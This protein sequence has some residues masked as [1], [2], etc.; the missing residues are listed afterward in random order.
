MVVP[1]TLQN[2]TTSVKGVQLSPHDSGEVRRQKFA[3][4]I[5]DAMYQFLGLLDVDGTVL[6]I[7]RAALEGA[8][9]VLDDVVGKPFWEARWWAVS[10]EARSQVRSMVEHAARGHFIRR[11]M[12]VFGD[13]HGEKSIFVDFS[14]TPIRDDQGR[15][16][17]LLPEGRNISEKVAIQA[18]LTRKNGELQQALERLREI[19]GF[20]TKF[21]ANVSHELRTPLTLILGPV[22]QLL[23][24]PGQL[25][26]RERARLGTVQRN[27]RSLL[28]QVNDL[29]DLARIDA[30]KMPLAYV[31]V[32]LTSLLQEIAAAFSASAEE[33]A[34]VFQIDSPSDLL[35]DVDR[36]K[37]VRIVANL[38]SNAFKFTHTGGRIRCSL[39]RVSNDRFLLSVQ[40]NGPGVPADM[41]EQI[42]ARFAQ[43]STDSSS[44]GSGLGLNIVKEFVELHLGTVVV[45][46][47][48]GGGAIFQVEMPVRAPQGTFVREMGEHPAPALRQQPHSLPDLPPPPHAHRSGLAHILVVEDNQDLLHFLHDVLVDN[49]NVTLAA[50]GAAAMEAVLNHTPDLIITD[51][52]MPQVDGM[53]LIQ[54][55]RAMA[56][57]HQIPAIV[58]TARCD[59]ALRTNLLEEFVQDYLTKPFSPQELR[60]RVHN[61]ITVKRSVELLQGELASQASDVG[62]LT[63]AL[64]T[65]RKFLQD[66][67][68][69]LQLSERRWLGLYE[70]TAVGIAMADDEG[71]IL[72]ANPALQKMLGYDEHEIRGLS[73]VEITEASERS[74][75]EHNVHGLMDGILPSYQLEKRYEMRQGGYL[76]ANVS[77]SRIPAIDGDGP[78]LAVIVEDISSR[79]QAESE[80]AA[81]QTE[82]VRVSRFTAMGELAASIAHEVNQ[83]LSAIATNSQAALRWMSR[84]APDLQEVAA[85]LNRVYR[86]ANLAGDVIARI[87]NFLSRGGIKH[88]RIAVQHILYDL[89]RMLHTLFQES[90]V[91]VTVLVSPA[92]PNLNADKVQ[93]QQVLLNLLINAVEAMR[94]QPPDQRLLSITVNEQATQ[95]IVFTVCDSGSGIAPEMQPKIFDALFSTKN[96][97]LGMG[98]A[99]SRSIVENHGGW[100]RLEPGGGTGACFCFNIPLMS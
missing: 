29:L 59:D 39:H 74:M 38:L 10:D 72:I 94:D 42:F 45:L 16:A 41:K 3:R 15:V 35:A 13:L 6:E 21:F 65:H 93:L 44:Y 71:R 79:K 95:G 100:L 53:Q 9:I 28:Q 58:L 33:R 76:W 88:E 57:F 18:E 7:N 73:L 70:N 14:L 40:D 67:L 43:A 12:E 54:E 96:D 4:V 5:L 11:D 51:L 77:A 17:F 75:T 92:L 64:V 2:L 80:L 50:N 82:L 66:S 83:P 56:Q 32:N 85:A 49:Y 37:F 20:K 24:E 84:D 26:E 22:E 69:A 60:A 68:L 31:H 78:W 87:R 46:D 8:G 89:L 30:D 47:A 91:Q 34:I 1:L 55:L 25:G 48:A 61:L 90:G 23:K 97:G 19:D 99:I 27:A 98:L 36:A 62:E 86:D 81:T 52:M 63:A